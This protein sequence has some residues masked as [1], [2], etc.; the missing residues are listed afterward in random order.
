MF[1]DIR[2]AAQQ[3]SPELRRPEPES[4]TKAA[5]RPAHRPLLDGW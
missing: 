4:H 1:A 3:V 5:A 2:V